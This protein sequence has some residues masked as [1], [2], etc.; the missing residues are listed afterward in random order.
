MKPLLLSLLVLL[1]SCARS[2]TEEG[3]ASYY[4]DKFEGRKTASGT[5]FRQKA[6]TVAHRTLPFGTKIKVTNLTNGKTVKVVVTD[7]GPFVSGRIIDLSKGA[8]KKI[9]M[10]TAGVAAVRIRYKKKR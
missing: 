10:T 5:V 6:M 2:I 9:D 1:A 3:K 8:A 7:R 4:A